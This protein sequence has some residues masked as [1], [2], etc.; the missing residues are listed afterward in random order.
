[1]RDAKAAYE[2]RRRRGT[3]PDLELAR[4]AGKYRNDLYGDITIFH[5]GT[6]LEL[7]FGP[8]RIA[9]LEHWQ[10]NSFCAVFPN[11]MLE[12]WHVTFKVGQDRNVDSLHPVAAP[13]ALAWYE[14]STDLGVFCRVPGGP[15]HSRSR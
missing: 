5:K 3:K 4:Y 6:A 10:D 13:W 12:A 2:K 8:R 11:P 7:R 15:K 9:E 14:D 1:M